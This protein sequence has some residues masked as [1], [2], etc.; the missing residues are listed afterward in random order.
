VLFRSFDLVVGV[1]INPFPCNPSAYF[2]HTSLHQTIG[3]YE[4]EDHYAMDLDFLLK[5]VQIATV[6][7]VDELWGNHRRFQGTKT[8]D[9]LANGKA[10]SRVSNLLKKYRK[11]LSIIQR[12]KIINI[13]LKLKILYFREKS[14]RKQQNHQIRKNF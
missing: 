1:N 3:F 11:N 4:I 7:Y 6:K 9:D 12:I 5:V 14:Q 13:K 8:F 10:Y 2:Y